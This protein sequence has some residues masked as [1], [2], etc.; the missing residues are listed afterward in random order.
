V[1]AFRPAGLTELALLQYW[2]QEPQFIAA[3]PND[4]W[5]RENYQKKI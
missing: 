4:D 1:I 3:D 2:N 5:R